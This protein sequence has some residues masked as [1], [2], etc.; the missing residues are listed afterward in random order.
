M[1]TTTV[2]TKRLERL[3]EYEESSLDESEALDRYASEK[4]RHPGAVV[5]IEE[6]DCGEHFRVKVYASEKEKQTF[7]HKKVRELFANLWD[8]VKT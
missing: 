1:S 2:N 8:S 7:Y 5:A 4:A 6:L 3:Y